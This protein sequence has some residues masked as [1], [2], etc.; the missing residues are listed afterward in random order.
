M[1]DRYHKEQ[2]SRHKVVTMFYIIKEKELKYSRISKLCMENLT[3]IWIKQKLL[4]AIVH[5]QPLKTMYS[6]ALKPRTIVNVAKRHSLWLN[7]NEKRTH[8]TLIQ[9]YLRLYTLVSKWTLTNINF[10]IFANFILLP[11]YLGNRK[12]Y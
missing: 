5:W 12:N 6:C 10:Y 1:V 7:I 2:Y 4:F 9:A 11:K 8:L 3:T